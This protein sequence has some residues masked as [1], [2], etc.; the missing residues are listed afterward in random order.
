MSR[1]DVWLRGPEDGEEAPPVGRPPI[2]VFLWMQRCTRWPSRL[3][4]RW[5]DS[6]ESGSGAQGDL[7]EALCWWAPSVYSGGKTR[8][9]AGQGRAWTQT[10]EEDAGLGVRTSGGLWLTSATELGAKVGGGEHPNCLDQKTGQGRVNA[11]PTLTTLALGQVPCPAGPQSPHLRNGGDVEP[12][13]RPGQ[14][15]ERMVG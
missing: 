10:G 4:S 2:P 14:D 1:G 3:L 9:G 15:S 6:W 13:K 12:P 8:V 11:S 5:V 7:R